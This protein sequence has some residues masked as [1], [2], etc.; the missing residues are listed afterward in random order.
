LKQN[1]FNENIAATKIASTY[2]MFRTRKNYQ[3]S[4]QSILTI[5]LFWKSYRQRKSYLEIKNSVSIVQH[6]YRNIK[7]GQLERSKF[8]KGKLSVLKIQNAYRT[9]KQNTVI[10]TSLKALLQHRNAARVIEKYYLVYIKKKK[11]EKLLELQTN[12]VRTIQ[13][14]YDKYLLAKQQRM[15]GDAAIKIQNAFR[16]YQE[17]KKTKEQMEQRKLCLT[18]FTHASRKCLAVL[19][20]QRW[21]R[22]MLVQRVAI[23]ER[24]IMDNAAKIQALWRG[25]RVRRTIKDK[26]VKEARRKISIANA[27]V[28]EPMKLCNR[29]RSALDY[30]LHVKNLSTVHD[31]LQHL[32]TVTLLSFKCC[33]RLITDNALPVIFRI[34]HYGNRSLPWISIKQVAFSILLN[35]AK[36]PTTYR[37]VYHQDES[38]NIILEQMANFRDKKAF[39]FPIACNLITVLCHDEDIKKDILRNKKHIEKITIFYRLNLRKQKLDLKRSQNLKTKEQQYSTTAWHR[40]ASCINS[41]DP[42]TAINMLIR[43]LELSL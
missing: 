11:Y 13:R 29:T 23:K 15:K 14:A 30:L 37:Y 1:K 42:F 43:R 31:A 28:T 22:N 7:H 33:E 32:D 8:I 3:K 38:M 27:N 6:W 2:K 36:C 25:Y 34:L 12:S 26:R 41:R 35:V 19:R 40:R 24:K 17:N 21:Y 16:Q 4:Y 20:M 18:E 10:L 9:Y 39:I 5:Q